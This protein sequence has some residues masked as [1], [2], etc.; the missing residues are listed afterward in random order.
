MFLP[1]TIIVHRMTGKLRMNHARLRLISPTLGIE[2]VRYQTFC[3]FLIKD[4]L[5][6]FL[7]LTLNL[8][9]EHLKVVY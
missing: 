3:Y 6:I 1:T 4:F 2:Q 5:I 7:K 9:T 8:K